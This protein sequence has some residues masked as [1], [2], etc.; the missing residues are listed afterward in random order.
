MWC[1]A[2]SI[3]CKQMNSANQESHNEYI[4]IS[5][6]NQ[7]YQ[8]N[9]ATLGATDPLVMDCFDPFLMTILQ[10]G[11]AEAVEAKENGPFNVFLIVVKVDYFFD[12]WLTDW[13]LLVKLRYDQRSIN[14]YRLSFSTLF[15]R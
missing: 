8:I 14:Y 5:W 2:G 4:I 10:K 12:N 7:H 1:V 9:K 6:S 13:L 15:I 3:V 11:I